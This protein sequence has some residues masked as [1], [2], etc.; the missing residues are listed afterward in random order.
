MR[1]GSLPN[2]GAILG[3]SGQLLLNPIH[4]VDTVK[5]EDQDKDKGDLCDISPAQYKF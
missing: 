2:T 3:K 5:E 1:E 4:T